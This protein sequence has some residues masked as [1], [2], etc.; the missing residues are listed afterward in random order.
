MFSLFWRQVAIFPCR[1]KDEEEGAQPHSCLPQ[2]PQKG[3]VPPTSEVWSSL[4]PQPMGL[5]VCAVFQRI[6]SLHHRAVK[7]SQRIPGGGGEEYRALPLPSSL[8]SPIALLGVWIPPPSLL[9]TVRPVLASYPIYILVHFLFILSLIQTLPG[10]QY[11]VFPLHIWL[12]PSNSIDFGSLE[13]S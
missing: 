9:P 3:D 1:R 4:L 5:E 6:L 7:Q 8:R 13:F 2:S 10:Y 12:R 11:L